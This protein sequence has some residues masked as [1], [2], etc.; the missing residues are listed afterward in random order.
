MNIVVSMNSFNFGFSNNAVCRLAELYES[1]LRNELK[2]A[3]K[4]NV[5]RKNLINFKYP[6][7]LD[8]ISYILKKIK[9]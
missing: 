9:Y 5:W 3:Y 7:F 6:N 2:N 1:Y 4:S 8:L